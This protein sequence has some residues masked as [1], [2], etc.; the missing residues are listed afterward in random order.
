MRQELRVTPINEAF[1]GNLQVGFVA[2][3]RADVAF[4]HPESFVAIKGIL[5]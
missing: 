4:A 5:P 3:L 1:M 2:H